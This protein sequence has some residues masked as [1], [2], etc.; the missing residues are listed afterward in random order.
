MRAFYDLQRANRTVDAFALLAQSL[1]RVPGRKNVVWVSGSF[2]AVFLNRNQE[3]IRLLNQADIGVYPVDARGLVAMNVNPRAPLQARSGPPPGLDTMSEIAEMTGGRAFYNNNDLIGA[4]GK[5][6]ADTLI[7]YT[8][9]FYSRHQKSDG[10]YHELNVRI[11][12]RSG[13]KLRH[14]NGYYDDMSASEEPS[15][16]KILRRVAQ[17]PL[18]ATGIG[19]TA[20]IDQNRDLLRVHV[21][22]DFQDLLSNKDSHW[23]GAAEVALVSQGVDGRTLNLV[24]KAI[25]FDMTDGAYA[26]RQRDGFAIEQNIPSSRDVSRIRVVILDLSTGVTGSVAINLQKQ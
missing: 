19:L 5:A 24:S 16:P 12:G 22:I 7:V 4:V 20:T 6:I 14:R 1:A 26:A 11:A 23:K 25:S 2:P 8:L 9:G 18:D 17:A 15:S 21:H 10:L 13:I 3:R